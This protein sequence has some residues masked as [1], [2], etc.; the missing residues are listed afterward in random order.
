LEAAQHNAQVIAELLADHPAILSVRY[1]GLPDHPQHDLATAQLAGY[2]TIVTFDVGT[3]EMATAVC[4]KTTLIHHATSL[5][6]VE[7]TM[8]RR[9]AVHGQDHL[10]PGLIRLSVGIEAAA[11]L[12]ADLGRAL[13]P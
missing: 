4:E 11:D 8:E 1:P 3:A 12:V 6:A 10:P 2:G 7:S 5:G 13:R 9:A